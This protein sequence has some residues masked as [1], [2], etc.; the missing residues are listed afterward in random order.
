M[1]NPHNH[2]LATGL[3]FSLFASAVTAQK[4]PDLRIETTP[5]GSFSSTNPQIAADGDNVYSVWKDTRNGGGLGADVYFN[6]SHD[7]GASWQPFDLRLDTDAPGSALSTAARMAAS[8]EFVYVVWQELRNGRY[9]IYFNRSQDY[10]HTWLDADV[11]LDTDAPGAADSFNPR[12]AAVDREVF[13]VWY[14]ERNAGSA[15]TDIYFNRSLDSGLSWLA[16]DLRLNVG[17][18]PGSQDAKGPEIA[19]DAGAVYVV[20]Q[21]LRN[22]L[23]D[24]LINRSLSSGT[25]G[26]WLPLPLRLN[27]GDPP[28]VTQSLLPQIAVQGN[29]V[30]VA[31]YERKLPAAADIYYNRSAAKGLPGSWLPAHK[32]LDTN[33]PGAAESTVPRIAADDDFVYVCWED[34]RNGLTDI[35]LNSSRDR[36][37]NWLSGDVRLD[38][39]TAPGSKMS[40]KPRVVASEGMAYVAWED[41]PVFQP[42]IYFNRTL[43]GGGS[44]LAAERQLD[45]GKVPGSTGS[46]TPELATS[47]CQFYAVWQ[48]L[49]NA[50]VAEYDVYFNV[51]FALHPYGSGTNG[52]GG[53][54][55]LLTGT[56]CPT[57]NSHFQLELTQAVGGALAFLVIGSNQ[58]STQL[59]CGTLLASLDVIYNL[60]LTGIPG[61]PGA[62]QILLT[63]NIGGNPMFVG[64]NIN[65]QVLVVDPGTGCGGAFSNAVELWVG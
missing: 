63:G 30:H 12:I 16:A 42:D 52:S 10:G 61:V 45:T 49:R 35:Y 24:I 46:R 47:G 22:G 7:R 59:S 13:I 33:F 6:R 27:T 53:F 19:A 14:D 65:Y 37:V 39:A 28:G 36:G 34:T 4:V 17:V 32:R 5:P 11:R 43:N 58:I 60:N 25:P 57:L 55:P 15:H 18:P 62:G 50:S 23:P 31:W 29:E 3:L 9:D 1:V 51:P 20:W 48:D 8:N 26:T 64:L 44:W 21:D 54:V 2:A 38:K 41:R 40:L 56:G